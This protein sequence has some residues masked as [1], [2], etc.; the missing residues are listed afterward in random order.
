MHLNPTAERAFRIG[1]DSL[2]RAFGTKA[3]VAE[4]EAREEFHGLFGFKTITS[5]INGV[6]VS[7]KQP[8][9]TVLDNVAMRLRDSEVIKIEEENYKIF[10]KDFKTCGQTVLFLKKEKKY[11]PTH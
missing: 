9:L 10:K 1:F 5:I 8:C 11:A 4:G 7:Q 3:I 2:V 6:E